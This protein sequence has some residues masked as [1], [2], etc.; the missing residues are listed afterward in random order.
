MG[1]VIQVARSVDQFV[2]I[3]IFDKINGWIIN[4]IENRI[5][6]SQKTPD[7][8]GGMIMVMLS[9][10]TNGIRILILVITLTIVIIINV[11]VYIVSRYHIWIMLGAVGVFALCLFVIFYLWDII[12]TGI[13]GTII[14]GI[15]GMIKGIANP[16]NK[17]V[18]FVKKLGLRI[19][20]MDDRGIEGGVPTLPGIA[21]AIA[22]PL[23]EAIL[24]PFK[25]GP[26]DY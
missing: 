2:N 7:Q 12:R 22:K 19:D 25:A 26:D 11:V 5:E 18:K 6:N 8:S 17:I 14:P 9:L 1:D 3:A 15:N 23:L 21:K 24:T 20:E 4:S 13:N 16:V 10:F